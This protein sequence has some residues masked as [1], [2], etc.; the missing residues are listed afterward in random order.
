MEAFYRLEVEIVPMF[1]TKDFAQR[2]FIAQICANYGAYAHF[3]A[4]LRDEAIPNK[5]L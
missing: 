5:I 1:V 3:G 4:Y 2:R